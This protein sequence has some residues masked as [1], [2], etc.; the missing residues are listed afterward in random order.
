MSVL[1]AFYRH[2]LQWTTFDQ[3]GLSGE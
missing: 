3:R 2:R 1:A